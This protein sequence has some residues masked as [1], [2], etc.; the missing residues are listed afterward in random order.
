MSI[1]LGFNTPKNY[2]NRLIFAV[3]ARAF[4]R[5]G[6]SCLLATPLL[7]MCAQWGSTISATR[8]IVDDAYPTRAEDFC[9]ILHCDMVTPT[10]PHLCLAKAIG[11]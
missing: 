1:F 3:A 11:L 2:Q 6:A 4:R 10:I 9:P 8:P 7:E 5:G